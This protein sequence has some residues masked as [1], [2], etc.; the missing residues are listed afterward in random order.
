MEL[1]WIMK[2]Q[3]SSEDGNGLIKNVQGKIGKQLHTKVEIRS[4]K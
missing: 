3:K 2:I 4:E 1:Y